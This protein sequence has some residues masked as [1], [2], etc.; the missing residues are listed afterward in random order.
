MMK[1]EI[2][3][4][5]VK[6]DGYVNAVERDSKVLSDRR[7]DFIERIKAGVFKRALNRAKR[8]CTPVK[9]LL[10]HDYAR[11]LT[12]TRDSTT[13]LFED[14]IGLRCQCEI[15]DKEVIEDARAGKLSGWSFGFIALKETRNAPEGSVE[16]R[17][18]EDLELKEVSILDSTKIP[19]YNG[20]SIETRSDVI[21]D[22]IEVRFVNDETEIVDNSTPAPTF[23]NHEWENRYM[24][25]RA[26][27]PCS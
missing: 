22:V 3:D 26:S 19:A 17:D 9:V 27:I 1:V 16:H 10:N 11:E 8:T 14:S 2:R 24:A 18:V 5:M 21:D 20:T 25:T 15:R 13:K 23:D 12:S 6:I 4:D 7:G